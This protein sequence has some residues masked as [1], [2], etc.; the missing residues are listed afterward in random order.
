MKRTQIKLC[1]FRTLEDVEMIEGFPVDAIG[2]IL[3]PGRKRSV[4]PEQISALVDRVPSG[5]LTVGVLM[6]PSLDE[7]GEWLS[8]APLQA[9]QL[10]GEEPPAFCRAVKERF[11]VRVIKTFHVDEEIKSPWSLQEYSPWIDVAL[12]DSGAG[13]TR[14]GTGTTFDWEQISSFQKECRYFQVP[15]WV[16]GGLNEENVEGLIRAYAPDGVDVSSGIE[17]DGKKDRE[18]IKRFVERVVGSGQI[19]DS[20]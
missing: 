2:F 7:I 4:S 18:K 14:G 5:V 10:H 15:L 13:K 20:V 6:N 12:L 17:S 3:V 19:A 16:A 11:P 9:I 8:L 1:G